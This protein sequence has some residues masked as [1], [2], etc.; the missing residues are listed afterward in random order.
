MREASLR[1]SLLVRKLKMPRPP[2]PRD[3]WQVI[4]LTVSMQD[5]QSGQFINSSHRH[6]IIQFI[7]SSH[8]YL[9]ITYIHISKENYI[10]RKKSREKS[11][12]AKIKSTY[13]LAD[14][15]KRPKSDAEACPG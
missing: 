3:R 8:R 7:N 15:A 1:E 6:L 4:R 2:F 12:L 10:A 14:L 5:P 13:L 11:H 9:I